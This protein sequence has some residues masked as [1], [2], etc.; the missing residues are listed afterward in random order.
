[1]FPPAGFPHSGIRGSLGV[2]PSPRLI[3]A[4]RALHRLRVPRHPPL[5]FCR[6]TTI[7]FK[8]NAQIATSDVACCAAAEARD[9]CVRLSS[10]PS[11]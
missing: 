5:A 4:Y 8:H 11:A 2:C 10:S 3:A 7:G 1:M 9:A 6:L